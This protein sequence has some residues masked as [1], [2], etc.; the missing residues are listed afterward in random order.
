MSC[1]GVCGVISGDDMALAPIE[2]FLL[3][4]PD[5]S[6]FASPDGVV[7]VDGAGGGL[8]GVAWCHRDWCM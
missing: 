7:G 2:S 8:A 3:Y 1:G 5:L 4:D 6:I